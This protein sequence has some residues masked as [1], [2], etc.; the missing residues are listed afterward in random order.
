[1]NDPLC[2]DCWF[3]RDYRDDIVLHPEYDGHC[4]YRGIMTLN[5]QE[6]ADHNRELTAADFTPPVFSEPY[7]LTDKDYVKSPWT[8]WQEQKRKGLI[9]D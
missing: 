2:A 1:M 7:H 4:W 5:V 9:H 6:C 8:E 3:W